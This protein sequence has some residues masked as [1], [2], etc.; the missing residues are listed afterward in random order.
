MVDVCL[1]YQSIHLSK[2]KVFLRSE[3]ETSM[4]VACGIFLWCLPIR[5]RRFPQPPGWM[6]SQVYSWR[7]VKWNA[8]MTNQFWSEDLLPDYLWVQPRPPRND[9]LRIDLCRTH[10]LKQFRFNSS[11][12]VRQMELRSEPKAG[13]SKM[14]ARICTK[15]YAHASACFSRHPK[16]GGEQKTKHHP[17]SRRKWGFPKMGVY[18]WIIYFQWIFHEINHPAIQDLHLWNPPSVWKCDHCISESLVSSPL[19]LE[20]HSWPLD[21]FRVTRT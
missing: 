21:E 13:K 9:F 7:V 14:D 18:P 2:L 15:K 20:S 19:S 11:S 8:P 5:L 12:Q 1:W 4:A 3:S 17:S 10:L 16:F 6:I